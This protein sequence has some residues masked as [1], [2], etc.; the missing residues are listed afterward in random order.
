MGRDRLLRRFAGWFEHRMRRRRRGSCASVN[1]TPHVLVATS[2]HPASDTRILH[3]EV[4][5]LVEAGYDVTLLAKEAWN[6][7]PEVR[8]VPIRR[9]PMRGLRV[10]LA[11][12]VV[13]GKGLK[14]R[15]AVYHLHDPELLWVGAAWKILTRAHVVF[16]VHENVP[17]QLRTK[18]WVL[19]WLRR[20]LGLVYRFMERL[21]LPL[22]DAV[23]LAEDSYAPA[24]AWHRRSLVLHNMPWALPSALR[25]TQDNSPL[26]VVYV[27]GLTR[28]R[29]A[30]TM[31]RA[32]AEVKRRGIRAHWRLI[33]PASRLLQ[34]EMEAFIEEN[35][36]SGTVFLEGRLSFPKAQ[37][38][39]AEADVGVAVLDPLPNYVESMP[40]KLLEYL[41]AGLPVI[42]SDFPLWRS[43]IEEF[44]CGA[45]V[46]PGDGP[47]LADAVAS[48]AA[49]AAN[50]RAMGE[51]G[52]ARLEARQMTWESEARILIDLYERLLAR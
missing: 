22:Y 21:L 37:A 3:K 23:I 8:L 28:P 14:A 9:F 32:A 4:R 29:G 27:G 10:L 30:T 44:E 49:D 46:P 35:D 48:M 38:A 5:S 13:F 11:P 47:A 41:A 20:P 19:P 43:L 6:I 51:N 36:L 45:T 42:A 18:H 34:T 33:G 25:R 24:Y 2:V 50:R 17:A 12:W 40:T 26:Q 16:D 39:V 15:A 1:E 31:L 7:P 52:R